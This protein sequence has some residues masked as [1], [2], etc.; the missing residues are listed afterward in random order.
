[1]NDPSVHVATHPTG[2]P[3]RT[4]VNAENPIFGRPADPIPEVSIQ[5]AAV[6]QSEKNPR[7][8]VQSP[9]INEDV[10]SPA[11]EP[12][13][14]LA[15]AGSDTEPASDSQTASGEA[16]EP[17]QDSSPSAEDLDAVAAETVAKEATAS[18]T[19]VQ[20]TPEIFDDAVADSNVEIATDVPTEANQEGVEV[21]AAG[22]PEEVVG[23][24]VAAVEDT[25]QTE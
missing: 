19:F 10:A 17:A 18:E 3:N 9:L 11:T 24:P 12:D 14:S 1:M 2:E 21:Y 25:A 4:A 13:P 23:Q 16:A 7:E 5:Q 6:V 8:T 20:T 22:A 15:G